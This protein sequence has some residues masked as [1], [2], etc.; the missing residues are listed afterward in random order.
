VK[1]LR[2]PKNLLIA[3]AVFLGLGVSPA[4]GH[5][6]LA[7]P[8]HPVERPARGLV[9]E[10]LVPAPPGSLCEG[11]FRVEAK[12]PT[13]CTHGPDPAPAGI[14]VREPRSITTLRAETG[15]E[16][17][18]AAADAGSSSYIPCI[19]DGS[20]GNRVQV[21]Y[22][23]PADR[24]NR[25]ADLQSLI[26]TWAAQA[27]SV[28]ADSAA[29]TG[30]SR[31]IRFVTLPSPDCELAI[32]NVTL[33]SSADDSFDNTID[34]L[35]AAGYNRSDRKYMV[36]MDANVLCG[37][38]QLYPD[39]QPGSGNA[40]NVQ[41]G[42][43]GS[44]GRT[45]AACWGQ[46][47]GYHS[48]EAHELV[49]NLGGVQ[50]SA[51]NTS[52]GYH[53]VDEYDT[54]CY[55]DE[56]YFPSMELLCPSAAEKLLDC[57]D[58]D[59]FNTSPP[60]GSYLATHWNVANSLFLTSEKPAAPPN[61]D[62]SAA[63]LLS[64]TEASRL[65]DTSEG[66]TKEPGEPAHA[67]NPGGASIWYRWTAPISGQTVVDTAGSSYDTLLG[68][69]EGSSVGSLV[70]VGSSDD[71]TLG[72]DTSSLVSFEA[73]AG[74][75]YEIA[76]DGYGGATGTAQLHLAAHYPPPGNDDFGAA[77]VLSGSEAFREA[78]TNREATKE[79]GEPEH[80]GN[81]GG[82]S[83]WYSWTAPASGPAVIET[84]GSDFDTLLGVYTG[85]AVS[86]LTEI[87]ADDDAE[88]GLSITSKVTFTATPGQTYRLA[89]D[90]FNGG[91]GPADGQVAISISQASEPDPEPEPE[92]DPEPEPGP[93][94]GPGGTILEPVP[95]PRP[96]IPAPAPGLSFVT[97]FRAFPPQGRILAG[98]VGGRRATF[99]FGADQ[100][101]TFSCRI[102]SRQWSACESPKRF[103]RL[104][105]G[106][107][108][109]GVRAIGSSGLVDPSP[110]T[111]RF[112]ARR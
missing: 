19:G 23:H 66:A 14:D 47:S 39:D 22:A 9:Y 61:D 16:G 93:G 36:Y 99:W 62:F 44:I 96:T 10:G 100:P 57:N 7:A 34:E 18:A 3:L 68:I 41:P 89:V 20:S 97:P 21:I 37:I 58:D 104:S 92:P 2:I 4:S 11:G 48:A 98:R 49:H 51:P 85:S 112:R 24:P 33:S 15:T 29:Q 64:G 43:P 105:P 26:Q 91:E 81:P 53:C 87:A 70:E 5:E 42:V 74:Q 54:E 25:F 75:T 55:S 101:A 82:M 95:M 73:V 8:A 30:G 45:D 69:Y 109:F 79:P 13:V 83:I 78:D 46:L 6:L 111:R 52:G 107:H 27:S 38:G 110:A 59:Y 102:D 32:A 76:V 17:Q 94:P 12:G 28:F 60:A 63:Q 72:S 56:P 50:L 31:L 108:V 106:S 65:G 71:V 35:H 40:N 88:P 80:A 86:S 84:A 90:G 67:G 77:T 1:T 103:R